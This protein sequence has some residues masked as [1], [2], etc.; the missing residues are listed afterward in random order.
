[1]LIPPS[2]LCSLGSRET[3][4]LAEPPA[5]GPRPAHRPAATLLTVTEMFTSQYEVDAYGETEIG[6]SIT[7]SFLI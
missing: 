2:P 7:F 4:L 1:M 3:W 6:G 5:A